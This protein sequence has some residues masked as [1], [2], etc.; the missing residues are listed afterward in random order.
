MKNE[1]VLNPISRVAEM[2]TDMFRQ[3]AENMGE[4]FWLR[5]LKDHSVLYINPA[6]EKIWGRTCQSL[7]DNPGSFMEAVYPED[8]AFVQQT[9]ENYLKTGEFNIEYR[10]VQPSGAIRWVR[11][12]NFPIRNEKGE[13]IRDTGL[14]VDITHIKTAQADVK[15]QSQ[16][17]E[18]LMHTAKQYINIPLDKIDDT[19][20]QSMSEIG[21]Y[22]QADRAYVFMYD[23][24][25]HTCSNTYEWCNR[26]ITPQIDELQDV[27]IEM[28]PDWAT[29]HMV[30]NTMY[31]EDVSKLEDGSA[32][33]EILAPQDIKSLIAVPMM[34]GN[35][36]VGFVGFDSVF[37]LHKYSEKEQNMLEVF[38]QIMVNI[39]IRKELEDNLIIQKNR[40]ETAN[41][42]KSEFLAN[43]SH[44]IRTP[45]NGVIGFAELLRQTKLDNTQSHY[46][47]TISTSANSLLSIINDILDFSKIEAGK[48]VLDLIETD[49]YDLINQ[50]LEMVKYPAN[51]KQLEI[52]L[53]I[54]PK[55]PRFITVDPVRLRQIVLNLLSNAL[56]FTKS[57]S[58]KISVSYKAIDQVNGELFCSVKDTGIGI[59]K[60]LQ[61]KLFQAFGQADSSTTR[62]YGGTGLGLTISDKLVKRMGGTIEVESEPGVGSTFSFSIH[63]TYKPSNN[64]ELEKIKP[65]KNVL[66]IEDD[67]AKIAE[68]TRYFKGWGIEIHSEEN[69]LAALKAIK[70]TNS[71]DVIMVKNDM[72]FIDGIDTIKMMREKLQLT[73][74]K[75]P[76]ILLASENERAQIA[77][78]LEEL[79]INYTLNYP[80]QSTDLFN[81]LVGVC[82]D[83]A[84]LFSSEHKKDL[85][86]IDDLEESDTSSKVHKIMIVEDFA[87]NMLLA[88][89]LVGQL[90]PKAEIIQAENGLIAVE[91]FKIEKP[92]I[93]FMD[94][95]MP[96]LDGNEATEQIRILEQGEGISELDR[97]PIVGLTA[98]AMKEEKEKCLASGMDDFLTKPIQLD[99]FKKCLIH[100]LEKE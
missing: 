56:K 23:W 74:E 7:Y 86:L 70:N 34:R 45:L 90:Y 81:T 17:Q 64:Q 50:T 78:S 54:N 100:F 92:D 28:I 36:C 20:N 93:I 18:I 85:D 21:K 29:N 15:Q 87:T 60:S 10:I 73:V 67:K 32:L 53:D 25:K 66:L 1:P 82:K 91:K 41:R 97:T 35:G 5:D 37:K 57:G 16:L 98:G 96:E 49:I 72:P 52:S 33:K 12:S 14:A 4:V 39:G 13:M 84:S 44:E 95:Q 47:E 83:Y 89:T 26:G 79:S 40:A 62:I 77:T 55:T 27:P 51:Q 58:I 43:M 59:E 63:T 31:I 71:F 38:A 65:I 24:E 19:I 3:I 68:V 42:T 8:L 6:Y 46:L 30:G 2:N 99:R 88:T 61:K 94:V 76:I 22:V 75:Q 80:I 11:T 48:L 9:Y 69:G